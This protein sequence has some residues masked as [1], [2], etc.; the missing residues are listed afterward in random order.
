M[1]FTLS[2]IILAVLAGLLTIPT[3]SADP[4]TP[5]FATESII[6][7]CDTTGDGVCTSTTDRLNLRP[8][9]NTS[10]DAVTTMPAGARF[11]LWCWT[12]SQSINGDTIWYWGRYEPSID[13]SPITWPIGWAA[14]YYLAT[15]H[16]PNS[17][18]AHC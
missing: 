18:I 2:A 10:G 6:W 15:G 16:D 5:K 11:R 9:P 13:T 17:L 1:R 7:T 3:A 8:Q 12:S 14:G 4:K